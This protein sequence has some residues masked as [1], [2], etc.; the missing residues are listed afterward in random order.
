[1]RLTRRFQSGVSANLFYTFAKSI[2]DLALAQNF[3]DQAA[4]RA[5]STNDH[6]HVVTANWVWFR[7][8]M[9]PRDSYRIRCG[10]AKALKD[11]TLSGSLTARPAR[12]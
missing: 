6:R 4:E 2:D 8:W 11:W 3:Y 12:L 1:M 10:S 5:L 7:R 9:R